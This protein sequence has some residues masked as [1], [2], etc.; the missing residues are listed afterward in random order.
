ME[1][2][3]ERCHDWLENHVNIH[4]EKIQMEIKRFQ[5]LLMQAEKQTLTDNI[6]DLNLTLQFL[7]ERLSQLNENSSTLAK[8]SEVV[9]HQDEANFE[10]SWDSS[11]LTSYDQ[12]KIERLSSIEKN[13]RKVALLNIEGIQLGT[14]NLKQSV[15]DEDKKA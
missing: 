3:S 15:K 13:Q 5:H 2:Y 6:D 11:S 1:F 7:Q 8:N 10:Q 14:S 4:P 12:R 9:P